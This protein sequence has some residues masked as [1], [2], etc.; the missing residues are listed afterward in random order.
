MTLD[1]AGRDGERVLLSG[2]KH[3][4]INGE[5]ECT[6]SASDCELSASFKSKRYDGQFELK[7]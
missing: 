3:V 1:V 2:T 6:G 4:G 5:F 7:R